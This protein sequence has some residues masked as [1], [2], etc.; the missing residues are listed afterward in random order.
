MLRYSIRQV[1]SE[2]T[3]SR[4]YS[5]LANRRKLTGYSPMGVG[6]NAKPS[7]VSAFWNRGDGGKNRCFST[8]TQ[9]SMCPERVSRIAGNRRPFFSR[10]SDLN[11]RRSET[12]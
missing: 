6:Q 8:G 4:L 7:D 3:L 1:R 2:E 9:N 12:I 10:G 5:S 11:P